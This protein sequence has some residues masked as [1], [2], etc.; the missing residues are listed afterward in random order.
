MARVESSILEKNGIGMASL[1]VATIDVFLLGEV[2]EARASTAE[3]LLMD[4]AFVVELSAFAQLL[5][6]GRKA[7]VSVGPLPSDW[8]DTIDL[9]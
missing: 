9:F 4:D 2:V 6:R 1:A 8:F 7:G 3:G 5:A